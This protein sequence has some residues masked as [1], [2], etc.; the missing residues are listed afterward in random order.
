[1]SAHRSS[2][3]SLPITALTA[4]LLLASVVSG[5]A[6]AAQ[7]GDKA[8]AS[9]GA[10]ASGSSAG[11]AGSSSSAS[12]S[13]GAPAAAKPGD[14]PKQDSTA[15]RIKPALSVVVF[16]LLG[17]PAPAVRLGTYLGLNLDIGVVINDKWM[18]IP[19]A[20]FAF[21]PETGNWGGTFN[22]IVDRYLTEIGGVTLT[23]EP[24]VGIVHDVA[25]SHE[26]VVD[27][28]GVPR[29][30]KS[31]T[32]SFYFAWALGLAVITSKGAII[33]Q[34]AVNVGFEGEGWAVAPMLFYSIPIP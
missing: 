24:S 3:P 23:L 8:P 30:D 18:I 16:E 13:G 21:S 31:T 20:G 7:T 26:I 34:L 32:H 11:S 29:L 17:V 19:S 5:E 15:S 14:K 27:G 1:M 4:T 25:T 33:P 6:V 2:A 22:L 12:E 28:A 9:S 10:P